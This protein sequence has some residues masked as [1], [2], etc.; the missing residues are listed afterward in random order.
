VCG[1][2]GGH[3]WY[4]QTFGTRQRHSLTDWKICCK[5]EPVPSTGGWHFTHHA[6]ARALDMALDPDDIRAVLSGPHVAQPGGPDYPDGYEIWATNRIA[7]VVRPEEHVVV[8]CLWRG[9]VYV[10]GEDSEPFRDN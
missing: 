4:S 7:L 2:E 5:G 6:L 9:T 8:T 10:R 3:L 1:R